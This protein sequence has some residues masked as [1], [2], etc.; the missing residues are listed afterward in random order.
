[1]YTYLDYVPTCGALDCIQFNR[2][3]WL[4]KT[5]VG[6]ICFLLLSPLALLSTSILGRV[7][8][9]DFELGWWLICPPFNKYIYWEPKY[10]LSVRWNI[11]DKHKATKRLF[12]SLFCNED[13]CDSLFA[14]ILFSFSCLCPLSVSFPP[15]LLHIYSDGPVDTIIL[16]NVFH[17]RALI[18]FI[19]YV[20]NLANFIIFCS[21]SHCFHFTCCTLQLALLCNSNLRKEWKKQPWQNIK[22]KY[23]LFLLFLAEITE[24][25]YTC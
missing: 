11:L 20:S 8:S 14:W 12:S 25:I 7:P 5:A 15:S 10:L 6:A 19:V 2:D 1:M 24:R 21:N 4:P 17:F 13:L 22:N 16:K 18:F 23:M 9:V 3:F